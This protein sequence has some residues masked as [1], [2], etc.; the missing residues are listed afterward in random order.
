MNTT[1][2]TANNQRKK[3]GKYGRNSSCH[4]HIRSTSVLSGGTVS[5]QYA[6]VD[7]PA[8][9]NNAHWETLQDLSGLTGG[10]SRPIYMPGFT[11]AAFLTGAGSDP[12]PNVL[13]DHDTGVG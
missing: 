7:A 5:I 10:N 1:T 4:L 9:G 2:L 8:L 6:V 11:L 13:I 3:L 12:V